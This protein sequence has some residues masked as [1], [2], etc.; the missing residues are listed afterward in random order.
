MRELTKAEKEQI[1]EEVRKEFPDDTVMQE[2]HYVRLLHYH[3]LNGLS[4][5]ERVRFFAH[6]RRRARPRSRS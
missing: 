6:P 2:V 1:W 5:S 4:A 3:Q